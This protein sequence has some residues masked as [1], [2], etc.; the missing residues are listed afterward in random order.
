VFFFFFLFEKSC[1]KKK[2]QGALQAIGGQSV[3]KRLWDSRATHNRKSRGMHTR[4]IEGVEGEILIIGRR[5][6]REQTKIKIT[7]LSSG[8]RKGIDHEGNFL[9][10]KGIDHEVISFQQRVLTMKVISFRSTTRRA[11]QLLTKDSSA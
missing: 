9:P 2:N 10:A 6:W 3:N 4:K 11:Y 5:A 8:Y 7:T 1:I